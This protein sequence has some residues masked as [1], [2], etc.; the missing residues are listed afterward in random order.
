MTYRLVEVL[1]Y[2]WDLSVNCHGCGHRER[3]SKAHFLGAWQPYLNA[4]VQDMA[5][6]IRCPKCKALGMF[7]YEVAGCY[8]HYGMTSDRFEAQAVLI[9]STLA[10]AGLDPAAYGYP[11]LTENSKPQQ[12]SS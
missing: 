8:A 6:R 9:R 2:G 11:P 7:V 5:K 4:D 1:E 10:D 3:R 12:M